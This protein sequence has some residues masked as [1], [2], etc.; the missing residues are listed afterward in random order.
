M[1]PPQLT[2]SPELLAKAF[3]FHFPFS[4]NREIVQTGDV[5]GRISP[6]PL[7]GKLI[8]QH[9]QINRPKI[10]VDF[11]ISKQSR[12]LFIV[13]KLYNGMQLKGQMMY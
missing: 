10:L 7:V 8:E 2:L 9:F 1:A 12:A 4:R 5:L 6:E 11:D 3:P 13:D